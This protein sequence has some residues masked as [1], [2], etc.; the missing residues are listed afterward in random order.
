MGWLVTNGEV[1]RK[2]GI[3][4]AMNISQQKKGI[5]W[6]NDGYVYVYVYIYIYIYI[7]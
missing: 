4:S 7:I 2:K 6:E 3:F 1:M 5:W